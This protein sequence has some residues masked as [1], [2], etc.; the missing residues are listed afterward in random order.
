ME[1]RQLGKTGLRVSA[2][3][4]GAWEIGGAVQLTFEGLGSIAHGWG[5]TDDATS[6]ALI[7]H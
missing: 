7:D 6:L 1:Y 2:V 5:A 3:S 4:L